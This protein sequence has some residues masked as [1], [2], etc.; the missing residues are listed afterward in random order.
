MT[1]TELESIISRDEDSKH[2][3]KADVTNEHALATEIIA[4]AN[5]MGGIIVIGAS[6]NGS[7]SG[8]TRQDIGRLNNL[9]SNASSNQVR[10][11]INPISE[12]VQFD[13][14]LVMVVHISEG[15]SKPYSDKNGVI[16]VKSGADKRKATSREEVQRMYQSAG[17]LHG[18]EVPV[19]SMGVE[20]IDITV[21]SQYYEKE[22]DEPLEEAGLSIP[23]LLEN[24]NLCRNQLLNIAGALLFG[25]NITH[26]LPT[27]LIKCVSYPGADVDVE[28]YLD[29]QD[30][31][32]VLKQV[33]EDTMG[34]ILRNVKRVQ[35][36]QN[37][38]SLGELEVPKVVFEELIANALIH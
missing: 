12:N 9:V 33:Y 35:G 25:K 31:S 8:L 38:N 19:P 1:P 10:P 5:A 16:W 21:L 18:D 15:I 37:V 23:R 11:P 13:E 22:Y 27:F 14:G 7:I 34:F 3:F 29:S 4:F 26:K 17:L 20:D 30:I 6:D 2:Q 24:L 28:R 32:G 36:D